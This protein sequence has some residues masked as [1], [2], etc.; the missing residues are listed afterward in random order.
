MPR[1]SRPVQLSCRPTGS[2]A[3][4]PYT[5]RYRCSCGAELHLVPR[6]DYDWVAVD[7]EGRDF[8]P[9][10]TAW[11]GYGSTFTGHTHHGGEAVHTAPEGYQP[12]WCHGEP[13]LDA[14]VGWVCRVK[15]TRF[16]VDAT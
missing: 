13:M 5:P 14:P 8:L 11:N 4:L 3:P 9:G 7:D 12:P 15:K 10:T 16:P 2:L 1:T 6:G